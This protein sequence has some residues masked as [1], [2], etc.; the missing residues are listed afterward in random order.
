MKAVTALSALLLLPTAAIGQVRDTLRADSVYRIPGLRVQATR[1]VTTVGGASALEVRLDSMN[2]AAAPSL[3]MVLRELPML[4]VRT[5]SRGEAEISA[6]GSESRQVAVLVDGIPL[7]LAWDSRTD[8]SVLPSTAF[9][10]MTY[11]RGLSSMLYGP[12]VLGGIIELPVGHS[13]YRPPRATA[14]VST[15]IDHVGGFGSRVS[16][17][18]PIGGAGGRWML[19]AGGSF[20]DSPGVPL[21]RG[22]VEPVPGEH[23]NLR[24][25]TDFKNLDGFG[26]SEERRVGKECRSR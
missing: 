6:R 2:L 13:S 20:S 19:R 7:T 26:R 24:T 21:A 10:E 22:I 5:N 23:D 9:R 4:H 8:A 14:E 18:I 17:I 12:N 16:A 1:P 3:E 11:V 15:G 25:N